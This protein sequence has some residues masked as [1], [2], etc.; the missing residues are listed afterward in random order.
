MKWLFCILVLSSYTAFAQ[1]ESE[2]EKVVPA[3]QLELA[4][5]ELSMILYLPDA[6]KGYYRGT[7]FDWSGIIARVEYRGHEFYGSWR[8]PHD[9]EGHDFVSGPAEEK[10]IGTIKALFGL[11]VKRSGRLLALFSAACAPV[12]DC[13]FRLGGSDGRPR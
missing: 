11:R 2:G 13:S 12:G 8:F 9:P 6:E 3:P 5:E 7:R 10:C 4:N 1:G